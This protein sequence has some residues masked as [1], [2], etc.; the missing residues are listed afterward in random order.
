MEQNKHAE[1]SKTFKCDANKIFTAISEGH[2]FKYTGAKMD[3]S[4]FTFKVGGEIQLFWGVDDNMEGV[5]TAI[6]PPNHI[7]F[8]WILFDPKA[9]K[10][11]KTDVSINLTEERGS[12]TVTLK[13]VGF[14]TEKSADDHKYGWDDAIQDLSQY[15][16]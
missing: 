10:K 7:G 13:H 16:K 4:K 8:T 3:K 12:T 5:F 2:L 11:V 9:D 14:V 15:L 1:V 6:R